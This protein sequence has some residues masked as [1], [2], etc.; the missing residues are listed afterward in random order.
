MVSSFSEKTLITA[1]LALG[2]IVAIIEN[3]FVPWQYRGSSEGTLVIS[4]SSS[5]SIAFFVNTE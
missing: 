5:G 1:N 2:F 3:T 4:H